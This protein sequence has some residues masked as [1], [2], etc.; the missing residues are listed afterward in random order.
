MT[1]ID[2]VFSHLKKGK[3]LTSWQAF[4]MFRATRLAD[5][6][7]RLRCKGYNIS[8]ELIKDGKTRYA[9]YRMTK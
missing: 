8:T 4:E 3:T 9:R 2:Q 6:V 5:I 7:L 1:K